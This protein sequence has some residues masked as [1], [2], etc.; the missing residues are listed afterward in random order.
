LDSGQFVG[1]LTVP[2]DP[3]RIAVHGIT[4]DGRPFR[5]AQRPLFRPVHTLPRSP[6]EGMQDIPVRPAERELLRSQFESALAEA[7]ASRE[8]Q[9]AAANPD[10]IIR[11]P[12][13]RVTDVAYEP[14]LSQS[15]RPLGITILYGVEVAPPGR[16]NPSMRLVREDP[17]SGGDGR[18]QM[19]PLSA[20]IT[21]RPHRYDDPDQEMD[22]IPGFLL[23]DAAYKSDTRYR[24]AIRF[25]PAFVALGPD[26]VT[27]CLTLS[28][29]KQAP[30]GDARYAQMVANR[31]PATYRV[32]IGRNT[33]EGRIDSY[34]GEGTLY[35]NWLDEGTLPCPGPRAPQ[36]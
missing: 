33:F 24:F 13:M 23:A 21:P 2:T 26:K 1:M 36:P 22:E 7:V 20:A 19:R 27:P 6:L 28:Y 8:R 12:Q 15:G 25:A 16:Y 35:Q 29:L 10:G 5:G 32:Y 18:D 9:V 17:V 30:R 11:L 4:H 3:F 31:G 14:Y 34:A